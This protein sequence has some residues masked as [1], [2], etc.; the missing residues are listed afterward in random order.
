VLGG[1]DLVLPQNA[2]YSGVMPELAEVDWYRKQWDAGVGDKVVAVRLHSGKYVL[3]ALDETGLRR[4]LVGETL[5]DSERHGKQMLFRFSNNRLLGIHLGMTGKLHV[6]AA[7]FK[8]GKYDHLV[9]CQTHHALV[10]TDPRQLGRVRFHSGSSLPEWWKTDPPQIESRRFDQN[11]LEQFLARHPNAPIK[12]VLLMQSGLAG[13]GNWMADEILWRAGILPSKRTFRLT[14]D[15]RK[16]IFRATK[17]IVQ[18]S[19]ATLGR[20]FSD[21]PRNW[22]IHQKWKR[23][24]VCPKHGT[25]LRHA[26]IGGR[27]TAWCSKCQA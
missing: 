5:I 12:A 17:F 6:E 11:F 2:K 15:E 1:W 7:D 3:R 27:T 16:A 19:L 21:P 18:T 13:I 8:P 23:E 20:N 22:L 14:S 10:F 4:G 26:T 9:L 24:G 25:R